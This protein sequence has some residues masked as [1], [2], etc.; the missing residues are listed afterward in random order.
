MHRSRSRASLPVLALPVAVAA[1]AALAAP[2]AAAVGPTAADAQR[3][4]QDLSIYCTYAAASTGIRSEHARWYASLCQGASTQAEAAALRVCYTAVAD[5]RA[6]SSSCLA[7]VRAG[8]VWARLD[9]VETGAATGRV[10]TTA[11]PSW[12][13]TG[14]RELR[15]LHQHHRTP[16][17]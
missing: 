3:A 15:R 4:R 1:A 5:R 14:L 10:T 17:A 7:D 2:A 11:V 8:A 16:A 12:H 9:P 13:R 6:V